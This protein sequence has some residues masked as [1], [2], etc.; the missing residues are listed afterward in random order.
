MFKRE[1]N[2]SNHDL[3]YM[4]SLSSAVL[5]RSSKSSKIIVKLGAVLVIWFLLWAH[6][7]EIDE[8][9]RG[10]GK[11]IPSSHIQVIQN[12]EGGIVSDILVEEGGLIKKD[13]VLV[14]IDNKKFFSSLEESKLKLDELRA[15]AVRLYAEAYKKP[16]KPD[17]KL[18]KSIPDFIKKERS[19]YLSNQKQLLS[20]IKVIDEQLKQKESELKEEQNRVRHFDKGY[21]YILR[22]LKVTEPMV[23]KGIESEVGLLKLKREANDL[24]EKL[25]TAKL[26]IPRI[27]SSIEEFKNKINETKLEFQNRAKKEWNEI[28]AEI[29]RISKSNIALE[30]KVK[31]TLIKS[32]VDG[33][34]K[35]IFVN[36]IGGVIKPGMDI[37][38]IVPSQD[39]LVAEVKI[40]PSDIAF[41]F[42]GQKAVIKLTAYDFS[43]YGGL[44]GK[45]THI[46]AD[47]I[48]DEKQNSY[49]LVKIKT[50]K[51]YIGNGKK[52]LH[53]IPGMT[54]N[55]DIL[56]GKK[57]V[58]DYLLKPIL[59]A[60]NNALSER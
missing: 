3:D 22:E 4:S 21:S 28:T 48:I 20:S 10:N 56:T 26:S 52:K 32:P 29:D 47:T 60:K 49:Y 40:K 44:D 11:V 39:K 19:L 35:Q 2:L 33:A 34:V 38:E 9:T 58:L 14:K 42:P 59:K 23:K 46:S 51:S 53:I 57:S 45:V 16:F 54:V 31:R 43:I 6:F 17:D 41:L 30:D 15:K 50:N 12:L 13:Q 8:I 7:A 24:Q 5:Q 1:D 27:E 37:M 25:E 18:L 55:V 36:T